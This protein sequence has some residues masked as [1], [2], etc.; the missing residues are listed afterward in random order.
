MLP[1]HIPPIRPGQVIGARWLNRL[2]ST[3]ERT[4]RL[5]GNAQTQVISTPAGYNL[6]G[7]VPA[8]IFAEL[9]STANSQGGYSW[10]EVVRANG[11]WM[12]TGRTGGNDP[13]QDNF[14]PTYERRTMDTTLDAS[15]AIYRMRRAPTSGEW[16]FANSGCSTATTKLCIIVTDKC[17]GN[18]ITGATVTATDKNGKVI[19]TATTDSSGNACVPIAKNG[20]YTLSVSAKGY[21]GGTTT[22]TLAKCQSITVSL[23][24]TPTT[25]PVT[26]TASLCCRDTDSLAAYPVTV[27]VTQTTGGSYSGSCVI[28]SAAGCTLTLPNACVGSK[29]NVFSVQF[30]ADHFVPVTNTLTIAPESC[31]PITD[32]GTSANLITPPGHFCLPCFGCLDVA[33]PTLTVTRSVN[34]VVTG[35]TVV[36]LASVQPPGAICSATYVGNFA[37]ALVQVNIGS[38]SGCVNAATGLWPSPFGGPEVFVATAGTV[39]CPVN[40]S[41]PGTDG[42]I[43][44]PGLAFT[45]TQ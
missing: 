40:F 29:A 24:I 31:P 5:S 34:G 11:Q 6:R 20:K 36:K 14:D 26:F 23:K 13:T 27:Q 12:E 19:G 45:V 4:T 10:K 28:T 30:S 15:G 42:T 41:G 44:I 21:C 33:P 8:E 1:P 9:T 43:P 37:L 32:P 38:L 39:A 16:M 7:I 2:I 22:A 35:Q 17:T 3:V 25:I 18:P